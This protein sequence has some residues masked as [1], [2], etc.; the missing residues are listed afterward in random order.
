MLME[1]LPFQYGAGGRSNQLTATTQRVKP[2]RISR[3]QQIF[4]QAPRPFASAS[5][6]CRG[7][8]HRPK[9]MSAKLIRISDSPNAIRQPSNVAR[10]VVRT[11]GSGVS[12]P[13]SPYVEHHSQAIRNY[14][15]QTVPLLA[16][17]PRSRTSCR[18]RDNLVDKSFAVANTAT[19]NN[20]VKSAARGQ[21][22]RLHARHSFEADYVGQKR[23]ST[24]CDKSRFLNSHSQSHG[25]IAESVYKDLCNG[26]IGW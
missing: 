25:V 14:L 9:T 4:T 23:S 24:T 19:T 1:F 21:G 12:S 6:N 20:R 16:Q 26:T 10:T 5:A 15:N 17:H 7:D 8:N 2:R 18:G 3:Q 11:T 22:S 13:E